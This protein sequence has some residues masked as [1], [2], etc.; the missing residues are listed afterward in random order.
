MNSERKARDLLLVVSFVLLFGFLGTRSLNEPDEGR[1]SSIARAMVD[2]GDWLVPQFWGMPHLDKPP[3]TYW[4]VALSLSVFGMNEWAVRL[5]LALAGWL[6]VWGVWFL[7]KRIWDWRAAFFGA[8]IFVSALLPFVMSR[9][10]TTDIF[11][12]CAMTWMLWALCGLWQS[13]GGG[14]RV[15][16][17]LFAVSLFS[18]IG[19]LIKGPVALGIPFAAMILHAI[20]TEG[21]GNSRRIFLVWGVTGLLL[22]V[23]IASPW[24]LAVFNEVPDA[25]DY[26]VTGQVVGHAL[27]TT[28]RNRQGSPFYFVGILLAGLLPWTPLLFRKVLYSNL[29]TSWRSMLAPIWMLVGATLFTFILFSLTK[30]KLPAYILP[31]FPPLALLIGW[32][33]LDDLAGTESPAVSERLIRLCLLMPG[34]AAVAY[35]GAIGWV[36]KAGFPIWLWSGALLLLLIC[37][38]AFS[39]SRT[40]S[41]EQVIMR[42]SLLSGLVLLGVG[43][44]VRAFETA[45]KSNQSLAEIGTKLEEE[46]QMGDRL[47]VWGKLP[48]GLAFY[49]PRATGKGAD[50]LMGMLDKT[51][52]PFEFPGNLELAAPRLILSADGLRLLAA[53]PRRTWIVSYQSTLSGSFDGK[54]PE[55][56]HRQMT[57][58]R[59]ELWT[60]F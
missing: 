28:I 39:K 44:S 58:G 6:T 17:W 8:L 9:M 2:S 48:Q 10:L 27:G 31:L 5:P 18:A 20:G 41:F 30:A 13:G 34:I 40:A 49:A 60:N 23:G 24:F 54:L 29:K 46:F 51:A 1:Y 7:G 52:V 14:S 36:F 16:V 22:G 4:L 21:S 12:T 59:W 32:S 15:L 11:L 35:A 26:M 45:L 50:A 37:V 43:V 33:L 25:S 57:S 53:G 3:M 42:A 55:T 19:F 38:R 47:V 56:L